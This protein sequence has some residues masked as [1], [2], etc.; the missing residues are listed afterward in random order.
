MAHAG[1]ELNERA[2]L[3]AASWERT[4]PALHPPLTSRPSDNESALG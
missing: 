4:D 2:T 1:G 3:K